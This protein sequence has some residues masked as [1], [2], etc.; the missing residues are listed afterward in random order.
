MIEKIRMYHFRMH[1]LSKLEFQLVK[2]K[3]QNYQ[4]PRRIILKSKLNFTHII[5]FYN[6]S[7]Y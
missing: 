7:Q 1:L 4:K 3:E 6:L 5:S 2:D